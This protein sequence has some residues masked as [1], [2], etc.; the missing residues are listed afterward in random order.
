[1]A[2]YLKSKGFKTILVSNGF[3][4]KAPLLELLPHID[5]FNIDLKSIRD[6]FYQRLATL[7]GRECEIL[8]EL[9][10]AKRIVN[11]SEDLG[12]AE[13]TV[14]NHISSIYFKLNIHDRL[15]IINYIGQIQYFLRH[16]E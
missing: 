3:I 15:E 10:M 12:I 2:I 4:N 5:A 14:R 1:M 16:L 9:V 13:Q 7:T 6:D 11:I 8:R